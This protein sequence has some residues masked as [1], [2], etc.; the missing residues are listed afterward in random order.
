MAHLR[1]GCGCRRTGFALDRAHAEELSAPPIAERFNIVR[2]PPG[3]RDGSVRR[4]D[5]ALHALREGVAER[6][7]LPAIKSAAEEIV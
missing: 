2:S 5:M 1:F 3:S 4:G 6:Q 7:Q